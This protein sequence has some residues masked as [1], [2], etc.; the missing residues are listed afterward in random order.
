MFCGVHR[1]GRKKPRKRSGNNRPNPRPIIARF[2]CRADRDLAWRQRFNLKE[3]SIKI[4]EDLPLNVREVRKNILIPALKKA[5]Q[6]QG[7]K[8][9]IIG[10][11]LLV[12]GKRYSFDKIPKKWQSNGGDG[13]LAERNEASCPNPGQPCRRR[14]SGTIRTALITLFSNL[15][16]IY[17]IYKI[18]PESQFLV[19]CPSYHDRKHKLNSHDPNLHLHFSTV[20]F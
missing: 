20:C 9:T 7:N 4:A 15:P 17:Y 19:I 1:L 10:D 16:N 3:S 18:K 13:N 2:T 11:R 14:V 6:N 12:N 5:R 8:A